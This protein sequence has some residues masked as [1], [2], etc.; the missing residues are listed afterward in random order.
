MKRILILC[1]GL[2][3]IGLTSTS[4]SDDENT[5]IEG[6][7]VFDQTG[8]LIN[9]QESLEPYEHEVGCEKDYWE[10]KSGGILNDGSY[11]NDGTNCETEIVTGTY[12]QSDSN[13]L[14]SLDGES[15]VATIITLNSSTLKLKVTLIDNGQPIDYITVFKR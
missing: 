12:A 6:K 9:G 11:Y 8:L 10:F 7:W 2:L 1:L 5:S 15:D 3:T 13:L 14:I 4:C